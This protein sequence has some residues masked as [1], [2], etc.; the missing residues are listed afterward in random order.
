MRP[1]R[2]KRSPS[3]STTSTRGITMAAAAAAPATSPLFLALFPDYQNAGV[4]KKD[5]LM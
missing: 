2:R 4:N 5:T 1:E 3:G